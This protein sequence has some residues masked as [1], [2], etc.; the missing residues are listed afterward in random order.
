MSTIVLPGIQTQVAIF[1]AD[2]R[3]IAKHTIDRELGSSMR[4]T[5]FI[6][7]D[8]S[9]VGKAWRLWMYSAQRGRKAFMSGRI[10]RV[11]LSIQNLSSERRRQMVDLALKHGVRPGRSTG[12]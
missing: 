5:A 6:D 2:V 12:G 7:D 4:V 9:K 8:K 10:D 11:I 3:L 1:G